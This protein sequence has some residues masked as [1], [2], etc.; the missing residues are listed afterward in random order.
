NYHDAFLVD[1]PWMGALNFGRDPFFYS[2]YIGPLVLLLAALGVMTRFRRNVFWL[3]IG[4]VFLFAA[5]G[6]Y[7]PAY[8]LAR[9]LFPPLMYFR[10]PAKYIVIAVF[11]CAVL[12]ADGFSVLLRRNQLPSKKIAIAAVVADIWLLASIALLFMPDP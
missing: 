7:T 12:A 5:L 11:A 10:F 3:A 9:R 6:G 2:L 1:L 4:L 8:P